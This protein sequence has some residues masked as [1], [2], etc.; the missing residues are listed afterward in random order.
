MLVDST[1][2]VIGHSDIESAGVTGDN[3]N[4]IRHKVSIL[5]NEKESAIKIAGVIKQIPPL[6]SG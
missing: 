2:K 6:R 1:F 4:I 3:I 5:D